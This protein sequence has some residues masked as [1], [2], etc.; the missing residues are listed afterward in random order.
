MIFQ[1]LTASHGTHVASIAAAYCPDNPEKN[2]IAPGAQI[3][4][5]TIGK[6]S[7]KLL[8]LYL[9]ILWFYVMCCSTL[10]GDNRLGSMETGTAL[11]RAM[12]RIM[13]QQ[14]QEE[15]GWDGHIDVINMSYG[16][17]AHWSNSGYVEKANTTYT[18]RYYLFVSIKSYNLTFL[19][20]KH[21]LKHS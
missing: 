15:E 10:S 12:T 19:K 5:L 11:V 4:S 2:G 20:C 21:Y 14:E 9:L 17:H 6:R 13:S 1:C 7:I 16:E 3:V 8:L 18:I